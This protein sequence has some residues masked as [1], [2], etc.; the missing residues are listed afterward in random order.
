MSINGAGI[1]CVHV[2]GLISLAL[3]EYLVLGAS[4]I[5]DSFYPR[6]LQ[7]TAFHHQEEVL[8]DLVAANQM[9]APDS[10]RWRH[11]RPLASSEVERETRICLSWKITWLNLFQIKRS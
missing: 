7:T 10:L 8:A 11:H 4:A 2:D 5:Q 9:R 1:E 3:I 6:S